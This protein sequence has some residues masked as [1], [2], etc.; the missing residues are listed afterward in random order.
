MHIKSISCCITWPLAV[1]ALLL[2]LSCYQYLWTTTHLCSLKDRPPSFLPTASSLGSMR[3]I[4]YRLLGPGFP[5]S[6]AYSRKTTPWESLGHTLSTTAQEELI[7]PCPART[8]EKKVLTNINL[9]SFSPCNLIFFPFCLLS[10]SQPRAHTVKPMGQTVWWATQM[11]L[12]DWGIHFWS[13]Q[14]VACWWFTAMSLFWYCLHLKRNA[15]PVLQ[16]P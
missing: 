4:L 14:S 3:N 2:S 11:L 15:S 10:A 5:F 8:L 1:K 6:E 9:C 13:C 12:L 16:P 7:Q